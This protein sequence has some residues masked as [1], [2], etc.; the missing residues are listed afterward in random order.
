[1]ASRRLAVLLAGGLTAGAVALVGGPTP[2]GAAPATCDTVPKTAFTFAGR[3]NTGDANGSQTA[4]EIVAADGDTAYVMTFGAIE[5]VDL[6]DPANPVQSGTIPLP[7]DPTSVAVHKGLVGGVGPRD[8][9]DRPGAGSVLRRHHAP[10]CGHRGRPARH[11]HLHL[12][13]QAACSWPTRGSQT[14]TA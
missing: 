14:A 12:H 5:V 3:Y 1:M 11:G 8:P 10:R 13:R 4:A 6:S 7:G 9:E 2:V